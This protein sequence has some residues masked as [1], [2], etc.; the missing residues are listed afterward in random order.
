MGVAAS[1]AGVAAG[2]ARECGCGGSV[3]AGLQ[4]ELMNIKKEGGI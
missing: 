1:G 3:G 4:C 2:G